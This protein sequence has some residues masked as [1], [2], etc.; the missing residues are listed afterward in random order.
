[1]SEHN[2]Q[3]MKKYATPTFIGRVYRIVNDAEKLIYIGSTKQTLAKRF[4]HH[5][6]HL[7]RSAAGK[8][9]ARY[10]LKDFRIEL[11]S[12]HIITDLKELHAI[13]Q[14]WI[15]RYQGVSKDSEG[16]MR[17]INNNDA[18]SLYRIFPEDVK[19]AIFN[20]RYNTKKLCV[21]GDKVSIA[22]M[23]GHL[24]RDRHFINL[25]QQIHDTMEDMLVAVE[26]LS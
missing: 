9:I 12:E 22:G 26:Q 7:G 6:S 20:Q 23:N 5:Y 1:M 10:G 11:I 18:F 2:A 21:C 4:Y 13:E 25:E 19:R 15:N 17:L 16:Y 3:E 14:L 24:L 8:Y